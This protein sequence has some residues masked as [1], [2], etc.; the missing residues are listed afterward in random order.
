MKKET[1][2]VE[3]HERNGSGWGNTRGKSRVSHCHGRCMTT[4]RELIPRDRL[5]YAGICWDNVIEVHHRSGI[6]HRNVSFCRKKIHLTLEPIFCYLLQDGKR[7]SK[8]NKKKGHTI[9]CILFSFMDSARKIVRYGGLTYASLCTQNID[10][11]WRYTREARP[12][13]IKL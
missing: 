2:T 7:V 11:F 1:L 3:M 13:T 9:P 4:E 6:C 5:V 10:I 12:G 8:W